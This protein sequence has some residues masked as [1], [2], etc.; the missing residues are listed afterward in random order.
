MANIFY[1]SEAAMKLRADIR[2]LIGIQ[3]EATITDDTYEGGYSITIS[4]GSLHAQQKISMHDLM[5][6]PYEK[7]VFEAVKWCIK[8]IERMETDSNV[9]D[10]RGDHI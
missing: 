2:A 7:L 9:H 3:Y 8:E 6:H 4:K 10:K 5:A 1:M